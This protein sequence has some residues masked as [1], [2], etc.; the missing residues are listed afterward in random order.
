MKQRANFNE[1]QGAYKYMP[2]GN[3]KA[4]VFIREFIEEEKQINE[5]GSETVLFV[6]NQNEFRVDV[7]EIPEDMIKNDPLSWMDY[8]PNISNV[9]IEERMEAIEEAIYEI[10]EMMFND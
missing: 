9:S 7:N 4:D 10:G 5:D 3:G 2:L 8:D 6:Y 1:K